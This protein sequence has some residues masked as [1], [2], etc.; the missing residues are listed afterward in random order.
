MQSR[1]IKRLETKAN[2]AS[3]SRPAT[4]ESWMVSRGKFSCRLGTRGDVQRIWLVRPN[5]YD[6]GEQGWYGRSSH[7]LQL[8][9]FTAPLLYQALQP[10]KYFIVTFALFSNGEVSQASSD[11]LNSCMFDGIQSSSPS[12]TV[13]SFCVR[14]AFLKTLMDHNTATTI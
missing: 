10:S 5:I 3:F 14:L 7:A 12:N 2:P 4:E 8:V 9:S 6:W 11:C 1:P 13:S